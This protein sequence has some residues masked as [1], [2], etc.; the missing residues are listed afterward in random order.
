MLNLV[1]LGLNHR[2]ADLDVRQQA[3]ISIPQLPEVLKRMI[4]RPGIEEG[5]IISTCNRVE[6]LSRVSES[7]T[8]LETLEAFF[9]EH[10][11][12]PLH[13]LK[14]HL[15][16]YVE[17]PAVR[18]IFRVASSLDSMILGE[19]QILG[20]VKTLFGIAAGA[21][22][23]GHCLNSLMQAAF[24][25]AK[26]VRSET[27]IGEF[28]VSVSSA[29]VEL[30]QKIFGDLGDRSILIVGSGKMGEVAAR[31]MTSSGARRIRV[32]NRN[33]E[34]A[35]KLARRS[36]GEAVP[37][38]DLAQWI[39][40]SDIVITSTG[41]REILIDR[42][43]ALKAAAERN[44]EPMVF[45]D[46]SVPRNIDPSVGT[47]DN[48]FCY[49]IDNLGAVVEANLAERQEAASRAEKIVE[50]EV[51]EFFTRIKARDVGPVVVKLQDKIDE[52]CGAEL[53][54]FIH[55]TGL[56]NEHETR[57]LE[58][59]ISRIASKISHPLISHLHRD[60]KGNNH[61]E[62]YLEI[63]KRVFNI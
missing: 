29:A 22:T 7:D 34:T 27:S 63:L 32:T 11:A 43:S 47:I 10:C 3:A 57:E 30:A 13:K 36:Q 59:M 20:Q 4:Q 42:T 39:G 53:K 5:M 58:W 40:K 37:F 52:I 9:A 1:I 8:G 60:A 49:D 44:H 24:H 46:I 14:S 31:H 17:S 18:H 51:E 50:E 48:V 19:T 12:I 21:A 54:R 35:L 45:I 55:R 2:T 28:S 56:H 6:L 41:S 38:E 16:H 15:Y 62:L 61:R 23:V 33:P 26:R 25:T